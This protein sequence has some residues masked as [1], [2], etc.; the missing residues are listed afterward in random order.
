[1]IYVIF[2]L[3]TNEYLGRDG[4]TGSADE[5]KHYKSFDSAKRWV[6]YMRNFGG[7]KCRYE[8]QSFDIVKKTSLEI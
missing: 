8:I 7:D 3:T 2:N 5:A 1:M 4:R 6:T